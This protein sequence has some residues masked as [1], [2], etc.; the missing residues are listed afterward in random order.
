VLDQLTAAWGLAAKVQFETTCLTT[1]TALLAS[2][3]RLSIL[4]R[5]HIDL[6]GRLAR[7]NHPP[8]PHARRDVG[9]TFRRTWLPTPF[10]AQF[11]EGL[12]GAARTIGV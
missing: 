4:S 6:D 5:W 9:L 12:R 2:S 10:Q 3:D 1:I 7:V 8:I 11:M